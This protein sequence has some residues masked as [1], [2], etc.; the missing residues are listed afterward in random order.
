MVQLEK[1]IIEDCEL[2]V[3]IVA[4]TGDVEKDEIVFSKLK[5]LSLFNLESLRSFCSG[6]HTFKFP[7]L[8]EMTVKKCP[9]MNTF[10]RGVLNTPKL[11]K[12]KETWYAEE[13]HWEGDLNTT[14]HHLFKKAVGQE[15]PDS[16]SKSA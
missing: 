13:K 2:M 4:N 16:S 12:V 11:A 5:S 7:A 14:I 10:S 1:M 6:N 3:E 15:L 9:K 8:E